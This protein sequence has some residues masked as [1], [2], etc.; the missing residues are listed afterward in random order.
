[1]ELLFGC[2]IDS[3]IAAH[4]QIS[5]GIFKNLEYALVEQPV[6]GC[7]LSKPAPFQS[8]K[9]AIVSPD[10]ERSI[11][12]EVQGPDAVARQSILLLVRCNLAV[13]QMRESAPGAQPQPPLAVIV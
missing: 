2:S 12:I 5:P 10:P 7:V 13:L 8:S 11:S 4:P 9:P 1:M 3:S 6:S